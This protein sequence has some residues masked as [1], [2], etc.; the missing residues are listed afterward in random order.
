MSSGTYEAFLR[1]TNCRKQI[2][3]NI[4]RGKTVHEHCHPPNAA[5][6]R[7]TCPYCECQTLE[8]DDRL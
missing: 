7:P 4:N 1:C 6:G 3:V 2:K 8:P 5:R